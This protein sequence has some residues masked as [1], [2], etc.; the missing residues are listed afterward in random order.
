M[1][2]VLRELLCGCTHFNDLHRGVPLMS[3][4]LLS[5]RLRRLEEVGAVERR[6][7]ARGWEYHLTEAGRDFAPIIQSLGAWAQCWFRS[8]FSH[9]ELDVGVLLWD[10][11]RGVRADVFPPGKVSVQFDFFDQPSSKRRW[12]LVCEDGQTDLC[13]N[14]PGYEVALYVTSDVETMA[15]IWMGDLSVKGAIEA[16][17]IELTG[18]RELRQRFEQW[19]GLSRFA[20]IQAGRRGSSLDSNRESARHPAA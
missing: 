4:S 19:L 8:R 7:G 5:R 1:P 16:G 11:R 9:D 14:N 13:P 2:L 12:W 6:R 18:A 3:R 15:R 17:G 10:M 20:I